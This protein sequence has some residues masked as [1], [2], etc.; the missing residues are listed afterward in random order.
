MVSSETILKEIK[1]LRNNEYLPPGYVAFHTDLFQ[2]QLQAKA[3]LS[4]HTLLKNIP[5]KNMEQKVEA[6]V[7]VLDLD[8]IHYTG[9]PLD[10]LFDKICDLIETYGKQKSTQIERLKGA[11]K[12][13]RLNIGT[14]MTR[15]ALK[16]MRYF[17]SL[18]QSLEV[19]MET[20]YYVGLQIG[21]PLFELFAEN[22]EG[23]IDRGV[24]KEGLCPVCGQEPAIAR[25]ERE[26]GRRLLHCWLCGTEWAFPRLQCPFCLNDDQKTLRFFFFEEDSPY[27]VDVCE[28]CKR[29]LKAIDERKL[30]EEQK[31]HLEVEQIGT[32]FLDIM[33]SNEGYGGPQFQMFD[34]EKERVPS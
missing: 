4:G 32:I 26:E 33:A 12:G 15:A 13:D 30:G 3:R 5:S 17:E 34:T 6:G 21:K 7:H 2:E 25:L 9:E 16:D 23:K 22:V 24:W 11:R 18:S 28:V 27:R 31:V 19:E 10:A 14:L 8:Q 20:L 29:Y 1:S